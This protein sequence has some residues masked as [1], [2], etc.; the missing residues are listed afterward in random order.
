MTRFLL[1]LS[2]QDADVALESRSYKEVFLWSR[3]ARSSFAGGVSPYLE[4]LG[5]VNIRNVDLVR[6][7]LGVLAADR[8]A[9]REGR[10]SSW[11]DRQ[12]E[13]TVQV[14]EPSVWTGVAAELGQLVGFLSGDHWTF[15]FAQAPDDD[16]K[17]RPPD[18]A[19]TRTVLLSGGADSAVGAL[20]S[21]LQL[22]DDTSQALVS[23]YS[24]NALSP[25]QQ[26]I[27]KTIEGH[28]PKV[29]QAHHQVH[30]NRG[31]KR[32]DGS[33][34]P[35]ETSTR[36]RSL[37]FLALGL[38]VADRAGSPLWIAENG[39]AS[40][41]PPLGPDRRG[42]LSTHTT[43][44]K[45]LHDLQALLARIG[46]HGQIENPF[47][48]LTKGQMFT[49]VA[50]EIGAKAASDYLSSTNSCSH[51]DARYSHAPSGSS[52][53]VCFGCLV[54]RAAFAASKIPDQTT[55]LSNDASGKFT[56]F[57]QQKSIVEPMRDFALRGMRPRD[58]MSMS[59]PAG[60]PAKDALDLCQR[61]VTELRDFLA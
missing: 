39:F 8:S 32:L 5:S 23:Q 52:C 26:R 46:A 43:H 17:A 55:Y 50:G 38:A 21:A 60:Y 48:R 61:G 11:N 27:V 42:S 9:L 57:V 25:I 31:S 13:L 10:G 19:H 37:L 33:A 3:S 28:V 56:A 20:M 53:G 44:P 34:Y 16:T 15:T 47:E 51:T 35:D 1:A 2:E 22:D 7:A 40:L 49:L 54:R 45:F 24:A 14:T 18:V 59:L 4:T 6:I 12:L 58:I 29:G 36:S 41:N 30:L